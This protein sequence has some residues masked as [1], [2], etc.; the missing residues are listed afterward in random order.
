MPIFMFQGEQIHYETTGQGDRTVIFLHNLGSSRL[1]WRPA[2]TGL[3]DRFTA[4]ALDFPGYG[5]SE[6]GDD[7]SVERLVDIVEAFIAELGVDEV[8]FV[9]NC[10]GSAVSML[11]AERHPSAVGSMVLFN[12]ATA[13]TLRPTSFG[14][15]AW[16][17]ARVPLPQGLLKTLAMPTAFARFMIWFQTGAGAT[18]GANADIRNQLQSLWTHRGRLL[19]LALIAPKVPEPFGHIDRLDPAVFDGIEM[20]MIWGE[21]NKVLSAKQGRQ[22]ADRLQV[23]YLEIS[24]AGHLAMLEMERDHVDRIIATGLT[25]SA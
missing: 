4:Y 1:I 17:V 15:L 21:R 6:L 13:A 2:M 5:S 18:N 25:V 7:P 23:P 20:Q 24:G 10:V 9:G 3:D 11:Y 14:R 12:P 19:P 22:L 16:L 8:D